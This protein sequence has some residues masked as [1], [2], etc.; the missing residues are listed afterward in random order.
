MNK[1]RLKCEG[2]RWWVQERFLRFLWLTIW[3][4]SL[5]KEGAMAK[6]AGHVQ[7]KEE[8]CIYYPTREEIIGAVSAK[9]MRP[10]PPPAPPSTP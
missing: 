1:F 5:T 7:E 3:D 4:A 8:E 9:L 6:I 10:S 2:G